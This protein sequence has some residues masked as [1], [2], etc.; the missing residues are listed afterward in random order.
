MNGNRSA[1]GIRKILSRWLLMAMACS[2]VFSGCGQ[3][4]PLYIPTS[5][6]DTSE[7]EAAQSTEPEEDEDEKT[8][9]KPD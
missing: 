7:S 9:S 6:A 1:T 5:P 2:L 3:K 4:G 8:N